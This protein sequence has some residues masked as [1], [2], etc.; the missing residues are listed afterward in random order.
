MTNKYLALAWLAV[1][2]AIA[3]ASDFT[4]IIMIFHG[5]TLLV[6]IIIFIA[7]FWGAKE[8]ENDYLRIGIKCAAASICF[9]PAS[10]SGGNGHFN[11]FVLEAILFGSLGGD[12]KYLVYGAGYFGVSFAVIYV[13]SL[14]VKKGDARR[15]GKDA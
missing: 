9:T 14:L 8:I 13:I 12:T 10:I 15:S 7:A 11:G 4:P 3:N 5:L 1:L 6:G 2:P